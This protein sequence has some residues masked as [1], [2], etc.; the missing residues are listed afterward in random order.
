MRKK[1]YMLFILAVVL[2]VGTIPA[3]VFAAGG[4]WSISYDVKYDKSAKAYYLSDVVVDLQG[5][6]AGSITISYP[7]TVTYSGTAGSGWTKV[8]KADSETATD[9]DRAGAFSISAGAKASDVKSYL[10]K[11]TFK[12][13]RVN[14]SGTIK[15]YAEKSKD[16]AVPYAHEDGTT[17]YYKFVETG[18]EQ[19]NWTKAYNDAKNSSY[20]GL[21]G[22][23]TT[24]TSS[25]EQAF[26]WD[27][28][29]TTP[30]WLGSTR[31]L[32]SSNKKINDESSITKPTAYVPSGPGQQDYYWACGPEAGTVF[33]RT[34]VTRRTT[35]S[36]DGRT[37]YNCF[38][39]GQPD[40]SGTGEGFLQFAFN[41]IQNWNDLPENQYYGEHVKGYYIEYG[42]YKNESTSAAGD[43]YATAKGASLAYAYETAVKNDITWNYGDGNLTAKK[44]EELAKLE[45]GINNENVTLTININDLEKVNSAITQKKKGSYTVRYTTENGEPFSVTVEVKGSTLS[46]SKKNISAGTK[47]MTKEDIIDKLGVTITDAD[48][49]PV[50]PSKI[51]VDKDQL[52]ELNKAIK[53]KNPGKYKVTLYGPDGTPFT[54]TVTVPKSSSSET[55]GSGNGSSTGSSGTTGSSKT[56][57]S[58]DMGGAIMSMLAAGAVMYISSQYRGK[59]SVK[60]QRRV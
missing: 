41:G 9:T 12:A 43:G 44:L 37:V 14:S 33:Y 45:P 16:A 11:I 28:I 21:K 1:R 48:G 35:N 49:H 51:T 42:G 27:S 39:D 32:D 54:V 58:R 3:M 36:I 52:N 15:V 29:A 26:I 50:D 24:I 53:N 2:I 6:S 59:R 40:G 34:G 23:L 31:F 7:N 60:Q 13:S 19:E 56:G 46:A 57:D 8:T 22:Y 4:N 25:K 47:S 38:G 30:G 55:P 10:E 5:S 17:H 20:L 18:S